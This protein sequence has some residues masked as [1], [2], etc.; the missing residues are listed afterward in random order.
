MNTIEKTKNS[1]TRKQLWNSKNHKCYYHEKN[2]L[3]Q[4]TWT[5]LNVETTTFS[6]IFVDLKASCQSAD[7]FLD[8]YRHWSNHINKKEN[9][10]PGWN[11]KMHRLPTTSELQRN[12]KK[13]CTIS[14]QFST[15][16]SFSQQ[17]S[18]WRLSTPTR[19]H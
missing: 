4:T 11:W 3:A 12:N 9:I 19:P 1:N 14:L 2:N 10:I 16:C 7:E 5:L 6:Y 8:N 13:K 15:K 17:F 18:R